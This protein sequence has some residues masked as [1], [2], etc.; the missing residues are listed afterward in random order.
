MDINQFKMTPL[1]EH[2]SLRP[3]MPF[4]QSYLR[5]MLA[6]RH[7]EKMQR[8]MPAERYAE[9]VAERV[10]ELDNSLKALRMCASFIQ[11]LSESTHVD[12]DAYQYHYENFLFRMIGV[13]DRA[14]RL[15]G[16][17]MAMSRKQ[18]ESTLAKNAIKR[19]AREVDGAILEALNGVTEVVKVFRK[20]RNELVHNSAFRTREIGLFHAIRELS[21]PVDGYDVDALAREYF[22]NE[23]EGVDL[24]IIAVQASL[25]KLLSELASSYSAIAEPT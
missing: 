23:S 16:A 22:L 2:E 24:K 8:V 3:L 9:M 4:L 18:I 1:I 5:K 15:V 21:M 11:Q 17:S 19:R 13:D 25:E 10:G 7:G 12:T 6:A 20:P 14:Y